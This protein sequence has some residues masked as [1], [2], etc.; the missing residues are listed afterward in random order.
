MYFFVPLW[1]VFIIYRWMSRKVSFAIKITCWNPLSIF[2]HR[3]WH[4]ETRSQHVI[5]RSIWKVYLDMYSQHTKNYRYR[6]TVEK[7]PKWNIKVHAETQS[8]HVK[9]CFKN[10]CFAH[11]Q[12]EF[13][14]NDVFETKLDIS[15]PGFHMYFSVPFG[16]FFTNSVTTTQNMSL[17]NIKSHIDKTSQMKHK[18]ACGNPVTTCQVLLQKHTFCPGT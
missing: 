8:W 17:C 1:A 11:V 3:T 9:F 2:W 4:L 7:P 15:W 16:R 6:I 10:T 14:K 12:N 18:S 13:I 5:S